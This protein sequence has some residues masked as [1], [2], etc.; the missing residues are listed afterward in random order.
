MIIALKTGK[1]VEIV[2]ELWPPESGSS[3]KVEAGGTSLDVLVEEDGSLSILVER[4]GKVTFCHSDQRGTKKILE[5]AEG[6][7]TTGEDF[8]FGIK[9]LSIFELSGDID[10]V[11]KCLQAKKKMV[12]K[13]GYKKISLRP[14][15]DMFGIGEPTISIYGEKE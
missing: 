14:Y 7:D 13:Q 10:D 9:P 3:I 11:I 12:E 1:N 4:L 5:E 2:E 8:V 6:Q 15:Q